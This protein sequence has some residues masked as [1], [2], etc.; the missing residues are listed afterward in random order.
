MQIRKRTTSADQN[1]AC[2]VVI[3]LAI[4]NL[5]ALFLILMR[6]L[7]ETVK[8]LLFCCV[9]MCCCEYLL[10]FLLFHVSKTKLALYLE[11]VSTQVHYTMFSFGP[12]KL[13]IAKNKYQRAYYYVIRLFGCH[14]LSTINFPKLVCFSHSVKGSNP[15]KLGCLLFV[16][17]TYICNSHSTSWNWIL[18]KCGSMCKRNWHSL[19]VESKWFLLTSN[20]DFSSFSRSGAN[21]FLIWPTLKMYCCN[22]AV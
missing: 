3:V 16:C 10:N 22:K 13:K 5:Y 21:F 20:S 2:L 12:N 4:I 1:T 19:Q 11:I 15:S 8:M 7:Q 6:Q 14:R 9:N 18:I 17:H